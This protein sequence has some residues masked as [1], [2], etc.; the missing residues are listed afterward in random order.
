MA[1]AIYTYLFFFLYICTPLLL[2]NKSCCDRCF[3]QQIRRQIT[4]KLYTL[5]FQIEGEGRINGETGKFR[6][7]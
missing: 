2:E 5:E 7:K 1:P 3:L 6:R 4:V